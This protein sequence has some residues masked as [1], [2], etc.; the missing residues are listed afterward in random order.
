MDTPC[1]AAQLVYS[2]GF[3]GLERMVLDLARGLDRS[4]YHPIVIAVTSHLPRAPEFAAA[5]IP[6]HVVPQRGLDVSLPWRLAAFCRAERVGL[7]HAH[8]FGRYFYGGP[9]ARLAGIPSL[10]TEHS[11][12]RPDER[13]LWLTQRRWSDWAT[14]VVADAS[15]VRTH[16][17]ARHGLPPERVIVIPNGVDTARLANRTGRASMRAEW[18]VPQSAV[19]IGTAGRLVPV[20]N[21]ALLL[22]AFR[23]L[24]RRAPE[25]YLVIA[26]DGPL[27]DALSQRVEALHLAD[28]V[29]LLG[30]CDDI[31][32]FLAGLDLFC[33]SSDSEGLPLAVIE[34]MAAG[35]PIVATAVGGVPE[36]V[37]ERVGRLA[38]PGDATRLAEALGELVANPHRRVELGAQAAAIAQ[39]DYSLQ[40]MVRRYQAV[41][42]AALAARV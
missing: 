9:A 24:R 20:K 27:R 19:V 10:Y 14:T 5:G 25:A 29:R 7:L 42:D 39:R 28:S 16:L 18:D 35:L 40:V 33:L 2:L 1:V 3:G 8:N 22:D 11:T 26:G 37:D 21:H 23:A 34:A 4:R 38:P 32:A 30:H 12:T 13:A 15:Y 17:I 6:V 41:Y 31:A 36:L